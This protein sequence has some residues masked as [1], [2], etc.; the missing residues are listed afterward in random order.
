MRSDTKTKLTI[1]TTLTIIFIL[2]IAL[3]TKLVFSQEIRVEKKTSLGE[4]NSSASSRTIFINGSSDWVDFKNAGNCTGQG[5]YSDPYIIKDLVINGLFSETCIWIENS[6]DYFKIENCTGYNSGFKGIYLYN[7]SNGQLVNNTFS[8]NFAEGIMLDRSHNNTISRTITRDNYEGIRVYESNNINISE[9]NVIDNYYI[10]IGIYNSNDT[11][12]D[13][14]TI[15]YNSPGIYLWKSNS[16]LLT[17][18]NMNECGLQILGSIELISSYKIDNTNVVNGKFLY[19]YFNKTGLTSSNFV[20]AGQVILVNCNNSVIHNLDVS[21]SSQGI[22]LFYCSNNSISS[23]IANNNIYG[24]SLNGCDNNTIIENTAND[25]FW[26]GIDLKESNNNKIVQNR[27]DRNSVGIGLWKSNQTSISDN[28]GNSNSFYGI[29]LDRS[30]NNTISGNTAN[31]NLIGIFLDRSSFNTVRENT[32]LENTECITEE[33]SQGNII[34]D[35][36]CE[37]VQA[38]NGYEP[39]YLIVIVFVALIFLKKKATKYT[40]R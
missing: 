15:E 30:N 18:N 13:G 40:I 27:V 37:E 14:N 28:I 10:G 3:N 21:H 16:T 25:C 19:Y 38:I 23:N 17:G 24:L 32:L 22:S 2:T 6:N 26:N 5:T 33:N 1:G 11:K 7:V 31:N 29:W 20:N 4:L 8:N 34:E 35:N 9:N 39:I 36:K 12:L